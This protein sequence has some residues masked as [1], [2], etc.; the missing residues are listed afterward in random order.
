MSSK[1]KE[2]STAFTHSHAAASASVVRVSRVAARATQS[3]VESLEKQ[4]SRKKSDQKEQEGG[5]VL[6]GCTSG[7]SC[8]AS[9][10]S[11]AGCVSNA[12]AAAL[13]AQRGGLCCAALC[14]RCCS[15]CTFASLLREFRG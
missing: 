15:R 3:R 7:C 10:F 13:C 8:G 11:L 4:Q 9:Q 6:A 5:R 14:S 12:R 1:K 2:S